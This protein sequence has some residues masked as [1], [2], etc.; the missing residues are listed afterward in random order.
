[1]VVM[2]FFGKVAYR[3]VLFNR[4][5]PGNL[6][7]VEQQSLTKSRLSRSRM[8]AEAKIANV[9]RTWKFVRT[10]HQYAPSKEHIRVN[11]DTN[12]RRDSVIRRAGRAP[13]LN[14]FAANHKSAHSHQVRERFLGL[15]SRRNR[16]LAVDIQLTLNVKLDRIAQTTGALPGFQVAD[17]NRTSQQR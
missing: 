8:T 1:M 11:G 6:A 4:T 7:R 15:A 16:K 14:W 12:N 5:K 3:I 10:T 13:I 17:A 9:L 2:L